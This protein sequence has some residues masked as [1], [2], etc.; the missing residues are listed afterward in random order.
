MRTWSF[1]WSCAL[2]AVLALAFAGSS[3][4]GDAPRAP[5]GN[6]NQHGKVWTNDDLDQLRARGGQI[7]TF[8]SEAPNAAPQAAEVAPVY[9][10]RLEDPRWYADRAAVLQAKLDALQTLLNDQQAALDQ[11]ASG[12][13]QPGLAMDQPNIGASPADGIAVLQAQVADVQS[14]LDDLGDLARANSIEPGVLRG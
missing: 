1:A 11:A 6:Q 2:G 8:G 14:Q 7:S 3:R 10:S 13:T 5:Q 4:A 12:I 9:G